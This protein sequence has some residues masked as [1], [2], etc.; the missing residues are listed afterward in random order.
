MVYCEVQKGPVSAGTRSPAV[1]LE[2][3]P[4]TIAVSDG[5]FEA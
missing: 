5:A 3:T 2:L 4:C 1:R